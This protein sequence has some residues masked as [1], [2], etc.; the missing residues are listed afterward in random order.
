MRITSEVDGLR[1]EDAKAHDEVFAMIG[2]PGSGRPLIKLSVT[3]DGN[4]I[5]EYDEEDLA[6]G[7]R[8]LSRMLSRTALQAG[9]HEADISG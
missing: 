7:I 6:D 2:D 5:I 1:V 4:G 9:A 8:M 3:K